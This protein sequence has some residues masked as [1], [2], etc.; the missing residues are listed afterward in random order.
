MQHEASIFERNSTCSR[1]HH[2]LN[3]YSADI[4]TQ[5]PCN[6]FADTAI[7]PAV[8]VNKGNLYQM[9]LFTRTHPLAED[10]L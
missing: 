9:R 10:F 4:A 1:G 6:P 3:V 7:Q 5:P 8:K 2:N